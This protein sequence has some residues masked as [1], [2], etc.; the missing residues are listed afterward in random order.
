MTLSDPNSTPDLNLTLSLPRDRTNV[1]GALKR[2]ILTYGQ[3]TSQFFTVAQHFRSLQ[4]GALL[5]KL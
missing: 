5:S 1:K 3:K 4:N 2:R